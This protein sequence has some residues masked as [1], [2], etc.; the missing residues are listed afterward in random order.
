MGKSVF[1]CY[2]SISNV[3]SWFTIAGVYPTDD[4]V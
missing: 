3:Y 2:D 4:E 1:F